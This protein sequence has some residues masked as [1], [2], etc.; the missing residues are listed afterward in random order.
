MINEFSKEIRIDGTMVDY[1]MH[2]KLSNLFLMCQEI[3]AD[4]A[5]QMGIGRIELYSK[6]LFWAIARAKLEI[7]DRPYIF[8]NITLTTSAGIPKKTLCPRY[9]I[10]KRNGV[11]IA[12][13][14]TIWMLVDLTSRKVTTP[15]AIGINM[16]EVEPG[17]KMDL[18]EK[19]MTKFDFELAEIR[20]CRYSEVDL[21]GHMNNSRYLDWTYDLFDMQFHDRH[22]LKN[23]AVNYS[24]EIQP[25]SKT[26]LLKYEDDNSFVVVGEGEDNKRHFLVSGEWKDVE[27]SER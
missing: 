16:P 7:I 8:D 21:N 1:K 2:L 3:A 12:K 5:D 20:K 13:M 25:E 4:H 9:F 23:I 14:S 22:E 17:I 27:V 24:I 11:V 15:E 26:K 18:P 10:I 19:V 6:N